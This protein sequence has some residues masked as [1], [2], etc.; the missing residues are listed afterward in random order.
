M[1][2]ED[3]IKVND[4]GLSNALPVSRTFSFAGE[5]DLVEVYPLIKNAVVASLGIG[6]TGTKEFEEA[7]DC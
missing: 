5:V 2:L 3:I 6:L 4:L 7:E 1:T